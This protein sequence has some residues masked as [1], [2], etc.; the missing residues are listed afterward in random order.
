M[1]RLGY[2]RVMERL[3]WTGRKAEWLLERFCCQVTHYPAGANHLSAC[4]QKLTALTSLVLP[5]SPPSPVTWDEFDRREDGGAGYATGRSSSAVFFGKFRQTKLL[6]WKRTHWQPGRNSLP[7]L[8]DLLQG[9]F[10]LV[11]PALRK[12]WIAAARSASTVW[13][14]DWTNRIEATK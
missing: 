13:L 11:Q 7:D 6:R 14:P 10:K 9:G 5:D 8:S 3:W 4:L 2:F 1:L 12:G